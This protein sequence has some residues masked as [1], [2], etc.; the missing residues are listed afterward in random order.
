M[1][2]A[3][4]G[5]IIAKRDSLRAADSHAGRVPCIPWD[6]RR[7]VSPA[8]APIQWP[9]LSDVIWA[10]DLAACFLLSDSA[11]AAHQVGLEASFLDE[12][13]GCHGYTL[14]YGA[15]KT[16]AM[17]LLGGRGP[18]AA[19]RA[20]FSRAGAVTVLRGTPP[21]CSTSPGDAVQAPWRYGW[22][23]VPHRAP[24][25]VCLSLGSFQARPGACLYRCRR[26]SVARRGALLRAMVLPRLLFGAGAWPSL[27]RGEHTLFHRTLVS[28]YRQTLC[29]PR[30][31][32]Q[33]ISGATMC[34]LLHLPDPATVLRVER[35]R[36]LRQLVQ[37]APDA[38]WAL[39]R[40]S[41]SS[42]CCWG[43]YGVASPEVVSHDSPWRPR[44]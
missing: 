6:G 1:Y 23:F 36:Y 24:R 17:V 31:E 30:N 27:R 43:C 41:P 10:D 5:C 20:L 25:Q 39:V 35:L 16:A 18:K 3:G 44:L 28:M 15:S 11:R 38:L 42:R 22:H 2:S 7:D 19:K 26:I 32:D 8:G 4:V 37:A 34:A 14:T 13:F 33:H 21:C 12:A 9:S 40:S 29:I